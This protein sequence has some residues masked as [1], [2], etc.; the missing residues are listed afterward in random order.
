M[1]EVLRLGRRLTEARACCD[2]AISIRMALVK[3][4]PVTGSY[5]SGLAESLMR[6][7]QLRASSGDAGGAAADWRRAVA[8]Y[9]EL[10][11]RSGEIALVEACCHAWLSGV[12]GRTGSGVSAS[13]G[14]DEAER[15]IAILRRE[16]AE[17]YR[18]VD[19]MRTEAGLEPLRDRPDFQLLLLD[20]AFPADPFAR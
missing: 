2:R 8:F 5:R 16:A 20:L 15:S 18:D 6:S 17:G 9:E 19:L 10:P 12:A 1:T 13:D 7:G 11:P 14:L 4:D 3:A